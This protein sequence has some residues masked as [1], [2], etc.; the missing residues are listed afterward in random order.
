VVGRVG[1]GLVTEAA[2][3]RTAF[4][5]VAPAPARGHARDAPS[6]RSAAAALAGFLP[7]LAWQAWGR[8]G[9]TAVSAPALATAAVALRVTR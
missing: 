5:L 7:G 1:V 9:V 6:A 3:W 8:P 2:G 4:A